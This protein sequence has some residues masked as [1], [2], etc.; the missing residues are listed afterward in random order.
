MNDGRPTRDQLLTAV[1]EHLERTV[2]PRLAG[3]E[4]Y[5]NRIATNLLRVLERELARADAAQL[6]ER[7]RLESL[8]GLR[9]SVAALNAQLCRRIRDRALTYHDETLLDHLDA[10]ALA[11]AAIDSPEYS[12]YRRAAGADAGR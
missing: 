7:E 4:A 12:A 10:T 2:Q 3:A 11:C 1:R 6:A 5:R 8:L 9:G